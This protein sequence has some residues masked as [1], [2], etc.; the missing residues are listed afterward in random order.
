MANKKK[1]S[2]IFYIERKGTIDNP[3]ADITEDIKVSHNKALLKEIPDNYEKLSVLENKSNGEVIEYFEV[4]NI[5]DISYDKQYFVDYDNGIVHFHSLANGRNLSFKYKGTGVIMYPAS[6][7]YINHNLDDKDDL[8]TVETLQELS[9]SVIKNREELKEVVD[10]VNYNSN[11]AKEQG[12]YAKEQGNY[13]KSEGDNA[14]T[15]ANYAKTQGDIAKSET[16]S[17]ITLKNDVVS[18]TENANLATS[19]AD[20]SADNADE[21]ALYAESKGAYASAQGDYAKE[22]GDYAKI[23]GDYAKTEADRVSDNLELVSQSEL[24][25]QESEQARIEAEQI[26]ESNEQKRIDNEVSR[27]QE[28]SN[29]QSKENERQQQESLRVSQESE[30]KGNE[31]QRQSN[32]TARVNAENIRQQQ[33]QERQERTQKAINDTETAILNVKSVI[34]NTKYISEWS[35]EVTYQTNNIVKYNGSSFISLVDNNIGNT[36][37]SSRDTDY[38]GILALRGVDGEGSVSSVN[39]LSPDVNGNVTITASDVN[40]Y[41]KSETDQKISDLVGSA[42]ETLDTLHELA[43][44]LGNNPNFATTISEQIGKKVDKV[45]GKQLSTEDYTTEEKMKLAGIEEGAN[46]YIHP[47]THP[48]TMITQDSNHR[49]VTDLQ[50][51]EWDKKETSNGAQEKAN[52]AEKNA[53]NYTDKEIA[54]ITNPI[55]ENIENKPVSF[56]PSEHNHDDRYYTETEIDSKLSKKSDI[57]HT[58]SYSELI[59]K[60]T[61]PTTAEEVGAI[62]TTEKGVAGGVAKLNEDGKVVD[63][64]GNEVGGK[65]KSVNGQTGEVNISIPAKVSEL[66]NDSGFATA[67]YVEDEVWEVSNELASHQADY[68]KHPAYAVTTGSANAYEVTL[69]PAPTAYEDGFGIVVAIHADSTGEST[70]NVNG[71]GAIP[72][73]KSNGNDVTNLKTNGIYTLRYRAGNFILQGEGSDFSDT[74]KS[75]LINSINTIYDM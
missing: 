51:N 5:E 72:I 66:E 75:N 63:A 13:A 58:H 56:T 44:A 15:Q 2:P 45:E 21:K 33:E 32:E 3:L 34:D 52:K 14:K 67:K 49:F 35:K 16:D 43:N 17:L 26:R 59:N 4:N 74:D 46:K 42:P 7:V 19:R 64:S 28:E 48:A 31:Q 57:G 20:T 71:L 37:D 11:H 1:T 8:D 23:Q 29:R 25:R 61:I 30:R 10:T 47:D 54:K 39:N 69:T 55:W 27:Q 38:W 40:A 22:Q 6:R 36:P 24:A 50:I 41:T 12:D 53:K 73:K 62:P 70:L 65:V 18:A 60:P 68:V 9:D